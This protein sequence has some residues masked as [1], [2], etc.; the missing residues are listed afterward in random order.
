[1][2]AESRETGVRDVVIAQ[3]EHF[4][5]LIRCQHRQE[6]QQTRVAESIGVEI[7]LLQGKVLKRAESR[8]NGLINPTYDTEKRRKLCIAQ[9]QYGEIAE[10]RRGK[11][12]DGLIHQSVVATGSSTVLSLRDIKLTHRLKDIH[13]FHEEMESKRRKLHVTTPKRFHFV[14]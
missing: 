11:G 13:L 6:K 3:R 10:V 12:G 1:M 2:V 4:K 14:I 8:Q 9:T 7:K 5:G